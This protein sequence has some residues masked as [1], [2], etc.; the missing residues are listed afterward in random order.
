[1]RAFQIFCP[2][3]NFQTLEIKFP[4]FGNDSCFP[5]FPVF[6]EKK[7]EILEEKFL[8]KNGPSFSS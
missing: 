8:D 6:F 3:L 1:M 7:E 2:L 5:A 4:N